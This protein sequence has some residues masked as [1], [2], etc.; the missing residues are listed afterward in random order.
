MARPSNAQRKFAEL[1]TAG[2]EYVRGQ[3]EQCAVAAGMAD[4]PPTDDAMLR[5]LIEARGGTPPLLE[6]A[7]LRA[8]RELAAAAAAA[9][10][11]QPPEPE[12]D[13]DPIAKLE[14]VRELGLPWAEMRKRLQDVIESV[15]NGSVR[16]TSAQVG[17]LKYI[18][19]QAKQDAAG[20]DMALGVVILPTQGS[21]A[22][23]E[24]SP[25]AKKRALE[26]IRAKA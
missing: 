21:A 4:T 9:K 15:A 2:P 16:A 8:A 23:L 22:T 26:A 11:D 18:I 17:M 19:E 24:L 12:P 5:R 25:A 10:A 3:W 20:E 7:G 1:Y 6:D 13:D 14:M